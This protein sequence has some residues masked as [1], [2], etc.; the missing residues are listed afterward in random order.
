[1]K[2]G[3]G[4]L[5]IWRKQDTVTKS[6]KD[7]TPPSTQDT[8]KAGTAP[9]STSKPQDAAPAQS[10]AQR[11]GQQVINASIRMRTEP[12]FREEIQKKTH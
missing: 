3:R 8:E 9:S 2:A 12:E 6:S 4:A 10:W 5:P 1:M 7:F 11:V